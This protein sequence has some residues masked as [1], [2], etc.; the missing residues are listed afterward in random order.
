MNKFILAILFISILFNVIGLFIAYKY[1][2]LNREKNGLYNN[3]KESETIISNLTDVSEKELT[4]RLVF[5]HHS[6]GKGILEEGKL[7]DSLIKMGIAVKSLTY[8]DSI[9]NLT[10]VHNWLP[11]FRKQMDAILKFKNHP[12]VYYT[13]ERRNDIIMFKSCFPN[14]D[15]GSDGSK[16]GNPLS[17][18]RTLENY[19]EVFI[20]LGKEIS[21]YPSKLFIYLTFPPLVPMETTPE[22]AARARS[23]NDWLINSYLPDYYKNYGVENFVIYDLFGV[24]SDEDNFLKSE[25]RRDNPR[26]S[27]PNKKAYQVITQD[28]MAFFRPVFSKWISEQKAMSE[29][30]NMN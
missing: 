19:K 2:N 23:F 12:N 24:L 14:S 17:R 5:L 26:D 7:K 8:G 1:Y 27:H 18:N 6:V 21:K 13:D 4:Y 15:I 20:G 29:I 16:P 3:L 25:Y 30:R 10:D 11:K 22:N 28:F 9:G